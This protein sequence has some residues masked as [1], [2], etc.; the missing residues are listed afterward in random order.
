MIF[1]TGVLEDADWWV[2]TV[3]T[4]GTS[5][6]VSEMLC[7]LLSHCQCVLCDIHVR[8]VETLESEYSL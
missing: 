7:E 1:G 4:F 8:H 3:W 2:G 5:A 6:K